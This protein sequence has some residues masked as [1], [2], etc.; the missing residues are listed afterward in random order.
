MNPKVDKFLTKC[1]T[2]LNKPGKAT[3]Q[4]VHSG[5]IPWVSAADKKWQVSLTLTTIVVLLYE[6]W[7][8]VPSLGPALGDTYSE[9]ARLVADQHLWIYTLGGAVVGV[10]AM[11]L[12]RAPVAKLWIRLCLL[13]WIATFAHVFWW[14]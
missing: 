13:G 12:L 8:L 14:F 7:A 2:V 5:L 1:D 11:V 9:K 4:W 3:D 10:F 6:A